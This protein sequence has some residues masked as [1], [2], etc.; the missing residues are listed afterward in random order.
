[1]AISLCACG[2]QPVKSATNNYT[3]SDSETITTDPAEEKEEILFNGIPWGSTYKETISALKTQYSVDFVGAQDL[4]IEEYSAAGFPGTGFYVISTSMVKIAEEDAY[5][6]LRFAFPNDGKVVALD[7]DNAVFEEAQY[8][9]DI[10]PGVFQDRY[11]FVKDKSSGYYN[12]Y[13]LSWKSFFKQY[14]IQY[15]YRDGEFLQLD[16]HKEIER[17]LSLLLTQKYGEVDKYGRHRGAND[18][19]VWSSYDHEFTIYSKSC[20]NCPLN[21]VTVI[22]N[23]D[24]SV[25]KKNKEI[26]EGQIAAYENTKEQERIDSMLSTDSSGL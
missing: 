22:Y 13:N 12:S 7:F 23:G 24:S 18:S 1:M 17:K 2:E 26:K 6:L 20:L 8:L 4:V 11:D 16:D 10:H 21:A 14:S 25:S 15:T 3:T 9:I 19:R 5:I